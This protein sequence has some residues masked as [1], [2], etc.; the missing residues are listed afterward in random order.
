M[1]LLGK[2]G[3]KVSRIALGAMA[4]GGD[5][6][7]ATAG[8]IWRAARD[9]G[10]NFIDTADVYNEGRSEEIIGRLLRA[11]PGLRDQLV[12]ASKAYFPT[13]SDPNARGSSRYHLVRAVEASLRRL[14]TDRIDLFYLHRFDDVT[15][16]GDTLRTL[17]DLV[18]AGKILYPA[19]S[20]FAAWQI[21][22]ALGLQR[23]AGWSPLVATQP[24]YNLAKRQVEVE[25]LPMAHSLGV[26]VVPYSPTGGGL[27]TGKYGAN[28]APDVGRVRDNKMYQVRYADPAYYEL[29]DRFTALAAELGHHPATLAVAWV[30][31][32]PAVTSVLVGGRTPAQLAPTLAA[33]NLVLDAET[34][35]RISALSPSPPPATDRNEETSAHNY[36]TR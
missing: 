24:M 31:S 14:A 20:N 4:F 13:G 16:L 15:D 7:E 5:A 3:V 23:A 36:G 30:A 25:I 26:A 6:D 1:N 17:D 22:H 12:I 2:T 28:R 9:A 27:F 35:A 34:R 32:H 8:E 11:E 18:R 29:A 19:C 21:A 10:V 33:A